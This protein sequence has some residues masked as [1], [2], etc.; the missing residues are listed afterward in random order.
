MI[1]FSL[2]ANKDMLL[3]K[4]KPGQSLWE[5]TSYSKGS[6]ILKGK[7]TILMKK[8]VSMKGTPSL[9]HL[10]T[11]QKKNK[12]A[13]QRG[14]SRLSRPISF[15]QSW[16]LKNR[17]KTL[18][19]VKKGEKKIYRRSLYISIL[20]I[21]KVLLLNNIALLVLIITYRVFINYCFFRRY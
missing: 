19:E 4:R 6:N 8:S 14:L 5:I 1:L 17:I 9:D 13:R 10:G 21:N 18:C 20:D 3:E 7:F 15:S 16:F 11:A 2:I 12:G